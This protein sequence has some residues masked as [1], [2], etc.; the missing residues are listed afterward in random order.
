MTIALTACI[1]GAICMALMVVTDRIM[2]GDCYQ[3]K[4]NHAWFVSS[5]AGSLFGLILTF[6][7][8]VG[9]MLLGTVE[10]LSDLVSLAIKLFLWKGV[11]TFLVG[12]IGIQ[13]L[14]HYFR[15]FEEK[16]HATA[17]ASWLAAT[18]IFVFICMIAFASLIPIDGVSGSPTNILWILGV[19]LATG[20]LILFERVS[21]GPLGNTKTYRKELLKLLLVNTLYAVMLKQTFSI[22]HDT[23]SNLT[24]AIALMPYYWLGFAAG[25]RVILK[26]GEWSTFKSN[27]STHIRFF[28]APILFVEIIGMLVFFFEYVG[29][30]GL[31]PTYVSI[32][33]GSHIFLVYL[34][35][36]VLGWLRHSMERRSVKQVF[37]GG[38]RF[39]AEKLPAPRLELN[40][41]SQEL[42]AVLVAT[43]GIALVTLYGGL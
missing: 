31:D 12:V 14:L 19:L 17:I 21:G 37:F 43:C 24:E 2:V 40:L 7:V 38:I 39:I 26:K 23:G 30:S 10:S 42:G 3:S 33:M 22:G 25:I 11:A 4:S 15:C 16:A 13:I 8:W 20:G 27:W 18:P 5:V 34:L 9:A 41:I 29:L 32:V 36:I 28:I 6:F 1:L 35:D